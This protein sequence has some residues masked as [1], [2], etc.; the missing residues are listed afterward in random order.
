MGMSGT[1]GPEM[2]RARARAPAARPLARA[3][4]RALCAL[5]VGLGLGAAAGPAPAQT[6]IAQA[7]IAQAPIGQAPIG[8]APGGQ[9]P[10]GAAPVAR[11]AVF[12]Y[13]VEGNTVLPATAVEEAV[14]AHLGTGR[15]AEDLERA[16]AALEEAYQKAG[17]PT[18]SVVIPQQRV[19]EGV[20]L[21]RVVERP[22][23]RLRVT[24]ARWFL[25]SE[26][27]RGA[28]SLAEGRVPNLP[29]V[30]RDIVDLNRL[31]DRRVT[32]ELKQGA[33]P[34][35]V[36][37]DLVVEDKLPLRAT[38]ELN[39]RQSANTEP[40]RLSGSL[41]YDNLWQRGDSISV[42]FQTAPQNTNNAAIISGSYLWRVPGRSGA[43]VIASAVRSDSNVGTVGGTTVIGA[44]TILGLRGLIPLGSGAG[45]SHSLTLG[46]DY[47]DFEEDLNLGTEQTQAPVTYYPFSIGYQ[48]VWSGERSVTEAGATI[49]A[50]LRG[51]GSGAD[52]F[53]QKR[54]FASPSWAHLRA[55]ASR[56]QRIPSAD[57]ELLARVQ[58]QLSRDP[59]ISNEQ[60][61]GGGLDSV[62]GYFEVEGLGD[63]G[64]VG[65]GEVRSPSLARYI[66]PQ[67]N[68]LRLHAFVDGGVLLLNRPL[69]QQTR[70]TS[71]ASTG[72][73]ARIRVL[74]RF[75][76]SIEGAATLIEGPVTESGNLRALFRVWGEF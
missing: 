5:A 51:L 58:G 61:G 14:Y 38:L 49:T 33:A 25:P 54:A 47:K 69:P 55:E 15:T 9:P 27:R 42:A 74:E 52:D 50:G 7:P 46:M 1:A 63:Y 28:P 65:Q 20:V 34:D 29:A 71:L 17:Y 22:V 76:G 24:G 21:L 59:L 4:P 18:V 73:G 31:P 37:V 16:R 12:E 70:R 40:L 26:V 39:N 56:L 68:E 45:F 6:P 53:E 32:P 64:F 62:R 2:V 75:N 19:T 57:V 13:Q 48:A 8:Q 36:D 23:G 44:G 67:V 11:F 30:Q 35:T 60:F 43:A 3:L 10:A 72:F 41:R 66:A